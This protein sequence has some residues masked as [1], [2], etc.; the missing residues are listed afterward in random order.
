MGTAAV[1]LNLIK[2]P[3]VLKRL[4]RQRMAART[5]FRSDIVPSRTI[6][7]LV[8]IVTR[9][10]NMQCYMCIQSHE[11]HARRES[12][13]R[14][15]LEDYHRILDE[16]KPFDPIIQITGGE[17]FLY[18]QVGELIET[19]KRKGFFCMINT[20]GSLLSRYA[21]L[22]VESGVE[23]VT[24]SID[25]PPEVHNRIRHFNKAHELA[26]EGLHALTEAKLKWRSRYPFVDVKGVILP[27]NIGLL[28][29]IAALSKTDL[30][31]MVDL[32]HIWFLHKSQVDAYQ[33]QGFKV[34]YYSPHQ[35]H[36][37]EPEQMEAMMSH[38]R[39]LKKRYRFYPFIVFPDFQD[40]VVRDFYLHPD[41]PVHRYPCVYPYEAVRVLPTGEV[42]ACP[43]DIAAKAPIGHLRHDSLTN[44]I[45]GETARKFLARLD[46]AKGAFP[47]CYRCCGLFRS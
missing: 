30:V 23:K 18:A 41:K 44:I 37:F 40:A 21:E 14:L 6:Q 28:E 47:V 39:D 13:D 45:R 25:G 4:L 1:A 32:V 34:G 38:I 26:M 29:P 7:Q 35:F 20:N 27:E 16:V 43:E 12:D 3:K 11:A 19:V 33:T 46:E 9:R 15:S 42:L 24:V 17:P 36:L 22:I 5:I 2:A 10:C 31:Q 8:L